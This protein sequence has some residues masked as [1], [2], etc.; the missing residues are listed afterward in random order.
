M[1]PPT[2][3]D[4]GD[5]HIYRFT[6]D[7]SEVQALID[8][9]QAIQDTIPSVRIT[10]LAVELIVHESGTGRARAFSGATTASITR[11]ELRQ[12]LFASAKLSSDYFVMVVLATIIAVIGLISDNPAVLVGA[13]VVAPFLGPNLALSFATSMGDR[14]IGWTAVRSL[15]IGMTMVIGGAALLGALWPDLPDTN[16]I[17]DRTV[18]G[19]E[20]LLLAIAS[21]AAGVIALTGA[22][23]MTLVGVMVAVALLP[24]AAV[25]G[26]K[27]G[28][29]DWFHAEGAALLLLI[30]IIGLNLAGNA[31]LTFKGITPRLWNEE[32]GAR[33]SRAISIALWLVA[34]GIVYV[35]AKRHDAF[36]SL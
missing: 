19:V 35:L 16:E 17:A 7:A 15:A 22:A 13:M 11:E 28:E 32:E 23:P 31:V 24:P 21:G 12:S 6:V 27:L 4:A 33:S 5:K 30:N 3:I 26:L 8:A 20:A 36:S 1:H 2:I 34:L 14:T 18:Y 9:A 29:G 10:V 25:V